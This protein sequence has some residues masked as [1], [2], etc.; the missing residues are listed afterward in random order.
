MV[1]HIRKLYRSQEE[2]DFDWKEIRSLV[3]T[4][5]KEEIAKFELGGGGNG[6]GFKSTAEQKAPGQLL[7]TAIKQL[8]SKRQIYCSKWS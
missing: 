5:N 3:G 6:K 2:M 4:Y 8:C 7:Q 1:R